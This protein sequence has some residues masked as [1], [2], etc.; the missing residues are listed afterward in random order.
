MLLLLCRSSGATGDSLKSEEERLRRTE[1]ELAR[2]VHRM[3]RHPAEI[4][5]H[6]LN[7]IFAPRSIKTSGSTPVKDRTTGSMT[8]K[9]TN[10]MKRQLFSL[11]GEP[12]TP[13]MILT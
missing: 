2:T 9:I 8:H 5:L 6:Q 7:Q 12:H 11:S 3:F 13:E 1:Q 4:K 10:A